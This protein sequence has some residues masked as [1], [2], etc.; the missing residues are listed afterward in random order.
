MKTKLLNFLVQNFKEKRLIFETPDAGQPDGGIE[1]PDAGESRPVDSTDAGPEAAEPIKPSPAEARAEA[2]DD[3]A[4]S[5]TTTTDELAGVT[6]PAQ[7]PEF[8]AH[9]SFLDVYSG[10][11]NKPQKND[12]RMN[13]TDTG[14][15]YEIYNGTAWIKITPSWAQAVPASPSE[16]QQRAAA[17]QLRIL[18]EARARATEAKAGV[19]TAKSTVTLDILRTKIKEQLGTGNEQLKDVLATVL[20]PDDVQTEIDAD[21]AAVTRL[22]T[23]AEGMDNPD[24][25]GHKI[26]EA[27]TKFG[28]IKPEKYLEGRNI[29]QFKP[30]LA[31]VEKVKATG[32]NE[33]G[34]HAKAVKNEILAAITTDLGNGEF[35]IVQKLKDEFSEKLAIAVVADTIDETPE[36]FKDAT[37]FYKLGQ[38]KILNENHPKYKKS[39]EILQKFVTAKNEGRLQGIAFDFFGSTNNVDH[40]RTTSES[41]HKEK[42]KALEKVLEIN[43]AGNLQVSPEIAQFINDN[44]VLIG[45][46]IQ[47]VNA[48][49]KVEY[50][51]LVDQNPDKFLKGGTIF[52]LALRLQR[53]ADFKRFVE[54]KPEP[55]EGE[56]HTDVFS[57]T[58]KVALRHQADESEEALASGIQVKLAEEQAPQAAAE[59]PTKPADEEPKAKAERLAGEAADLYKAK[60]YPEAVIKFEQALEIDPQNPELLLK[61]G[62]TFYRLCAA[63]NSEACDKAQT[64]INRADE[65][66]KDPAN[67]AKIAAVKAKLEAKIAKIAAGQP[68]EEEERDEGDDNPPAAPDQGG[69]GAA[70][71]E[72]AQGQGDNQPPQ[73]DQRELDEA[74]KLQRIIEKEK[75]LAIEKGFGYV[76]FE[77]AKATLSQ[78]DSKYVKVGGTDAEP[79]IEPSQGYEFASASAAYKEQVEAALKTE[80]NLDDEKWA[81]VRGQI[82][83]NNYAVIQKT[84]P[85]PAPAAPD[86]SQAA[87]PDATPTPNPLEALQ[88]KDLETTANLQRE[89]DGA[90]S[91]INALI[92]RLEGTIN[93]NSGFVRGAVAEKITEKRALMQKVF[94]QVRIK[95]AEALD[96][97]AEGDFQGAMVAYEEAERIIKQTLEAELAVDPKETFLSDTSRAAIREIRDMVEAKKPQV[98]KAFHD[99]QDAITALEAA[100]Q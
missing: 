8:K 44:A 30:L 5:L 27:Q 23:E 43:T 80:F 74:T 63:D 95:L 22:L 9:R 36:D 59:P 25:I 79:D 50:M 51:K 31:F 20:V 71:G 87:P 98:E 84:V 18:T 70:P 24:L 60:K 93:T 1:D 82:G 89:L 65:L 72:G 38:Y 85:A 91:E 4:D 14:K 52:D 96:K 26:E 61:L 55:A 39:Q 34:T 90:S 56:A 11:P 97:T 76:T 13:E 75:A 19:E 40:R 69:G 83:D 45:Q 29:N 58:D 86:D 42:A 6:I 28:I 15:K 64:N 12:L 99:K 46:Y 57:N 92:D 53:A 41:W 17:E 48:A 10:D 2:A 49:N 16:A 21:F 54:S 68:A 35:D 88:T 67:K 81:E 3:V 32:S 33:D 37:R 73:V 100:A 47:A 62:V 78:A 94:G 7:E 66:A 77:E